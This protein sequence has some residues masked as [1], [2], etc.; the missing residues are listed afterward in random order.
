MEDKIRITVI[1][2][3]FERTGTPRRLVETPVQRTESRTARPAESRETRDQAPIPASKTVFEPRTVNTDD[4][5]VP[6]FLRNRLPNKQ[7]SRKWKLQA[8]P[9]RERLVEASSW[10]NN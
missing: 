8:L 3:G 6:T 4:L 2:T 10:G 7:A 1:A 9:G 5:D